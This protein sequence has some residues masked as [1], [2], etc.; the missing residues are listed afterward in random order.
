[1]RGEAWTFEE[2]AMIRR[3]YRPG[4]RGVLMQHLPHR[5]KRAIVAF[6]HRLRKTGRL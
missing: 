4:D 2:M 3:H 6:T 5:T 1:M